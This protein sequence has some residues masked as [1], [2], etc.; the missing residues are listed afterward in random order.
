[1]RR[2]KGILVLTVYLVFLAGTIM[3]A[4][5]PTTHEE[6]KRSPDEKQAGT[7]EP[8][9]ITME[10]L[11]VAIQEYVE[12]DAKLKGGYFLVYDK[13]KEEPLALKLVKVHEDRLSKIG[14]NSFFACA[15]FET[16]EGKTYDLDIF[17][18]GSKK[19]NLKT[20]EISV[21]KE[22]GVARYDW[23]EEGGL[24]KKKIKGEEEA[25]SKEQEHPTEHPR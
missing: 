16:K 20:T 22:S 17:M 4:E 5:H 3:S 18:R 24:W 21:H 14:P 19:N 2:Y 9:E 25:E 7:K 13:E 15:D 6:K 1:M 8:V 12:R 10:D 11:A 23:Y